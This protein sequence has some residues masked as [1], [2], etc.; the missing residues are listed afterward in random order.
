[1]F[2]AAD[3]LAQVEHDPSSF[4]VLITASPRV[5]AET[6][7]EMDKQIKKLT[8]KEIINQGAVPSSSLARQRK[9]SRQNLVQAC[10]GSHRKN[11]Q[12]QCEW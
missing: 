3:L 11:R 7:K 2:L 9:N 5:A 6:E 8:R 1:E 12:H 4:A 10:N